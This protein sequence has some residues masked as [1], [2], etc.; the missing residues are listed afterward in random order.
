MVIWD[1]NASFSVTKENVLH[2][3]KLTPYIGWELRGVVHETIVR[4]KTV[5]KNGQFHYDNESP[6]GTL[7]LDPRESSAHLSKI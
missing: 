6:L 7:L 3:N 5:F 1:P 2:K 4:G